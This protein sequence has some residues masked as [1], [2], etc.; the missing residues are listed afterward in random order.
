MFKARNAERGGTWRGCSLLP[1]WKENGNKKMLRGLLR[2][3]KIRIF[4]TATLHIN[5][6]VWCYGHIFNYKIVKKYVLIYFSWKGLPAP[7]PPPPPWIRHCDG[8][9]MWGRKFSL[10]PEHLISL[11][12]GEFMILPI[13]YIYIT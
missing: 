2:H 4:C 9:H 12:L 7:L 1:R 8:C 3:S 10:F 13:R 6:R 5:I 11:Y